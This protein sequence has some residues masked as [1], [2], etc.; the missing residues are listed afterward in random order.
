MHIYVFDRL[1]H[2][3]SQDGCPYIRYMFTLDHDLDMLTEIQSMGYVYDHH[4]HNIIYIDVDYD[5]VKSGQY[6]EYYQMYYVPYS[7]KD[8]IDKLD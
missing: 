2:P 8:F 5:G 7:L 6:K 3:S 1:I 4:S